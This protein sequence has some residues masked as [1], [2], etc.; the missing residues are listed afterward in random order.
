MR[1]EVYIY[2]DTQDLA[3]GEHTVGALLMFKLD[4]NTQAEDYQ[5]ISIT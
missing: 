4:H 5:S 2:M 1:G 3:V